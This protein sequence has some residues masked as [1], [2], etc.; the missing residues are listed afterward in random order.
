MQKYSKTNKKNRLFI[1]TEKYVSHYPIGF[2]ADEDVAKNTRNNIPKKQ[3]EA[4]TKRPDN[5]RAES[6]TNQA[7]ECP[8]N[9]P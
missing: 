9:N 2:W 4:H 1:H 3:E 7:V 6:K 5:S 8:P